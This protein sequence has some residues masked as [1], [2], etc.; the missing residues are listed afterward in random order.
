MANLYV[1]RP[2]PTISKRFDQARTV[3]L[4]RRPFVEK[5]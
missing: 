4:Y 2:S 1:A 3:A 5:R